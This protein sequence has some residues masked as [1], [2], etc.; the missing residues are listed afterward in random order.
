MYGTGIPVGLLIDSKGPRPG[1]LIGTLALGSGYFL[2][3][4]GLRSTTFLRAVA[5]MNVLAHNSGPGSMGVPLICFFSF[6]TGLGS[7]SAFSAAIKTCTHRM[8]AP[9]NASSLECSCPELAESPWNSY[10][11]SPVG[12][13]TKRLLLLDDF[14]IC[15]S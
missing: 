3:Y 15:I 6:L 10:C 12:L 14:L 9:H 4:K 11:I 13:R 5:L 2:I 7:C 1:V 8:L